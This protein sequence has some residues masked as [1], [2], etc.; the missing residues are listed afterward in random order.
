MN[1]IHRLF[2]VCY[3]FLNQSNVVLTLSSLLSRLQQLVLPMLVKML[4]VLLLPLTDVVLV[5]A[6]ALTVA[7]MLPHIVVVVDI[8]VVFAVAAAAAV[9][10]V[11]A[12]DDDDRFLVDALSHYQRYFDVDADVVADDVDVVV[13]VWS[14]H[15]VA[16]AFPQVQTIRRVLVY[17]G[18]RV[19]K[20]MVV[21]AAEAV[22][23]HNRKLRNVV[24]VAN[25]H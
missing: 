10:A 2:D 8:F 16:G 6:L 1:L 5:V 19:L 17:S 21:V 14:L 15:V 18:V 9:S 20:L 23:V 7:M 3:C 11:D 25:Y 4:P 24:A 13:V 12:D 22:V